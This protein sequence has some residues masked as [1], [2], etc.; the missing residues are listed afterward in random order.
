MRFF[1]EEITSAELIRRI[2]ARHDVDDLFLELPPI[3]EIVAALY[4]RHREGEA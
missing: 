4:R 2:T 1:P 3:E